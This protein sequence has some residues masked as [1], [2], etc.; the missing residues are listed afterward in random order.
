LSF[1]AG[2]VAGS[3]RRINGTE[4]WVLPPGQL[5]HD[6]ITAAV[7]R[8]IPM[9]ETRKAKPWRSDLHWQTVE[10]RRRHRELAEL[11]TER[12]KID[13]REM[14]LQS[15]L[16]QLEGSG[17]IVERRLLLA[18]GDD[19][20]LGVI[21]ALREL[22]F[23]VVDVD[24]ESA[25]PGDKVED[26]HV[27]DDDWIALAEVRGYG[28]SQGAKVSDLL[29]INRFVRRWERANRRSPDAVWYIV[30]Q[31]IGVD[32]GARPRPLASNPDEVAEFQNDEGLVIDTRDLFR[33]QM[34]VRA[35]ELPLETARTTL[36]TSRGVWT[37]P[38]SDGAA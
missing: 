29:R 1:H 34:A 13:D 14:A 15:E 7:K 23:E 30:N 9:V 38:G 33:L 19:L 24:E 27:K 21:D 17:D 31:A 16:E 35:S 5:T 25:R 10:E 12:R 18:Q 6:W 22:D 32:P 20:K 2:V 36:K 3:Y 8:W 11:D 4:C 26:L 37:F 28:G